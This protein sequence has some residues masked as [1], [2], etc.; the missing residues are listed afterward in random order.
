MQRNDAIQLVKDTFQQGFDEAR[1]LRFV[2]ELT[3]GNI[4][5]P[6]SSQMAVPEAFADHVQSCK[7]LGTYQ[8]DLGEL[9]DILVVR[10]KSSFK[11]ER[12]RT[13]LRNFVA[14]KLK[15]GDG[16]AN[17]YKEA[18]LVAFV[19][20]D[21]SEWRFSLVRMEYQSVRDPRTGK[22]K[23]EEQLTPA[24][25]YS[26]LVGPHEQSHTAQSRF[27]DLLI[28]SGHPSV[29]AVMAAFSVDKVTN[30]FFA[31]YKKLF[32]D[33]ASHLRQLIDSD[34]VLAH[35]FASKNISISD[36]AKK[37]LGQ[38]VF[39][40]FLQKKGW[41]G[42][43]RGAAWGSGPSDFMRQL[44]DLAYQRNQSLFNDI[45]E[46]LFYDTL[47]VDRALHDDWSEP[48]QARIPFLNGGLFEPLN[49]YDWRTTE[50]RLPNALFTNPQASGIF[51]VFDRYNFT[52]NEAE[53]L[54]TEV[55]IDPEM[56]GKVFENLLDI[57]DRAAHGAFYT[58]REIV[59]YMCQ[60]SLVH[61]LTR[62]MQSL[63]EPIGAADIEY[64]VYHG[65][66]TTE[67]EMARAQG[68]SYVPRI[69]E[70]I[71]RNAKQL[72][73]ALERM[74]VLDPAIG[75]GAFP[76]GMMNEIVRLRQLLGV[77]FHDHRS[78]TVYELKRHTIQQSLYGVDLAAGAVEIAKLRLWLSLVVDEDDVSRIKPLPNLDFKIVVGNSLL[79]VQKNV[80]NHYLFDDLRDA[81]KKYFDETNHDQKEA[82]K[83]QINHIIAELTNNSHQFDY[84]IFF[85]EVI[86]DKKGFDIVIGNPP[87][88]QLQKFKG[89]PIQAAYKAAGY[90]SHDVAGDLYCLFYEQGIRQLKPG[91]TLCYIT[92]NKWMRAG[93][94]EKLRRYFLT[95]NPLL[96]IDLGPEIFGSATVD[97]NILFIA[98]DDYQHQLAGLTL[99]DNQAL[100]TGLAP[101]VA[102]NRIS[103]ADVTHEAWFIG[104]AAEQALKAK[105]ARIGK[106]LKA[107]DVNIYRGVLTGLNEAFIIDTATRDA[108]V[109]ADPKSAEIIKPILRGRD[110]K[111]YGAVWAG[112]WIIG[113]F[114]AL[115]LDIDLYPGIK[116]YLL[117]HFD[118]RQLEQSGIK[119]QPNLPFNA[120]KANGNKWFETQDNIAY[121]ANFAKAKIIFP[122][123]TKYLPF[124]YE[125]NGFCFNNKAF[126]ITSNTVNLRY[127][128][129]YM[130][131]KISHKWIREN[132]PSLGDDRREL[133]KIFMENLP[134][135]PITPA[136]QPVVAAIEACVERI[137]AA[138]QG[139]ITADTRADEAMID[140]LVYQLYDL[141]PAE[142]ALIEA[143]QPGGALVA[144]DDGEDE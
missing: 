121:Y 131:S 133:R 96:L 83:D 77:Y 115:K 99:T 110:I 107:W 62:A 135:P 65:D 130:N 1:Y 53:P 34:A 32:L 67:Y 33:L 129:G 68:T 40:Y 78:R 15:R 109:A 16:D 35:D 79:G 7:R 17:N 75:S 103:L 30:E 114:P 116:E 84:D 36:F 106:S 45:L 3:N 140:Q 143:A 55:A 47:N 126:M 112:L 81:K 132:C 125:G 18:G 118:R 48:L 92:S 19:S 87:Y 50:I 54:E 139:D 5:S 70:S 42:V 64:L 97:S 11:L 104:S 9:I 98:R 41:L 22:Y 8:S 52:V 38:I 24:R 71:R 37:L 6:S 66:Q 60:V 4:T 74:T 138:K 73:Q 124:I 123:I 134:I 80:L 90:Q 57:D 95:Q 49:R 142:I 59:H 27:V 44:I 39:L 89:N 100:R 105:I 56:L 76:V 119:Y 14:H 29:D 111:R 61:Y 85:H 25:R 144:S 46:P 101:V 137:L 63:P 72:D 20:A 58:P 82:L 28:A 117:A 26:Y 13:A 21:T 23:A 12:T 122:E 86:S 120:R 141:T 127:L 136:N 94:G 91:G 108:I 128:T 102:A 69:P 2:R 43:A 31:E 113:T 51:D 93:Y 88:V 10:V